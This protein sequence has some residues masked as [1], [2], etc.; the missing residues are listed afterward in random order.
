[1][2]YGWANDAQVRLESLLLPWRCLCCG[3]TAREGLDLCDACRGALPWNSL[4]CPRCA[5]PLS[6]PPAVVCAECLIDPPPFVR[7]LAPLRYAFPVDRLLV[8]LKFHGKLE[9]GRMLGALFAA[10]LEVAGADL[11]RGLPLLPMPLHRDRLAHRGFNQA[12]EL[13][14]MVAPLLG[15]TLAPDLA[16]RVRATPEQSRLDAAARRRNLAGAFTV[17]GHPQGCAAGRVPRRVLVIDD[18]VTTGATVRELSHTLRAA[19]AEE[20][21]VL[22]IARAGRCTPAGAPKRRALTSRASP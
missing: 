7:L 15:A 11:A 5:L 14:R 10:W 19:G 2:V 8:G 18:V 4:A 9:H 12:A 21:V 17:S 22:A 3:A 13:A 1:M 6:A 16:Q 20:V